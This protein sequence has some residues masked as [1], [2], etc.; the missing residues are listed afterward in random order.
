MIQKNTDLVY[1]LGMVR[2][3][4][5]GVGTRRVKLML[6]KKI[7]ENREGKLPKILRLLIETE[8]ENIQAKQN[9]YYKDNHYFYKGQFIGK[10]IDLYKQTDYVFGTQIS[11]HASLCNINEIPIYEKEWDEQVNST[12]PKLSTFIEENYPDEIDKIK[13]DIEKKRAKQEHGKEVGHKKQ[14]KGTKKRS[15]KKD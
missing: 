1:Q 8:D 13:K 9:W 10:L 2:S 12:L 11:F 3:E 7:K 15:V 5:C 4:F 14:A 6:N